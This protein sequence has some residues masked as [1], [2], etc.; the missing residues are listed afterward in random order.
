MKAKLSVRTVLGVVILASCT[1]GG[2]EAGGGT[3]DFVDTGGYE[4]PPSDFDQP[5]GQD[6][7]PSDYDNPSIIGSGPGSGTDGGGNPR[8]AS[9]CTAVIAEGCTQLGAD[10]DACTVTCN[11]NIPQF[12]P[13]ENQYLTYLTCVVASPAFTCKVIN[14]DGPGEFADCQG[15]QMAY[16]NCQLDGEGGQGG[17]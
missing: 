9:L 1:G 13:C 14:G 17:I 12:E 8:C 6:P 16:E 11:E 15:Q 4:P 7:P 2:G 5:P 10:A 3:G